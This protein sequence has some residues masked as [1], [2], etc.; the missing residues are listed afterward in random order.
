MAL[1]RSG[2]TAVPSGPSADA[3]IAAM[4]SAL[5]VLDRG[6]RIAAVNAAA[7]IFLNASAGY[8]MHKPFG[9]IL[10]LPESCLAGLREEAVFASF[11]CF[12]DRPR[13]GRTRIDFHSTPLPDHEGWRLVS[14]H[15]AAAAQAIGDRRNGSRT[16]IGVAAMLAHEIKNPLSGIRGAAQ[17]LDAE[18][19]PEARRMTKLIRDEVDRVAGLIDRMEQFTDNRPLV[20]APENIYAILDH[21]RA[22]ATSGFGLNVDMKDAFDPSLPPVLVHRDS[23]VQIVL[24][25]LKNASEA[26]PKGKRG[27]IW[28]TTGYRH[29]VAVPGEGGRRL[30][31]P[32]E[33]CVIDDGPGPPPEIADHLFEPF[34]SS[35]SSGRGLGL[36][37]VDK[38]VRDNGG[39]IQFAREGKPER[40]VFRMLLPRAR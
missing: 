10:R 4:P 2:L 1:A 30:S 39:I 19:S 38:L 34:V 6:G 28:L 37:L 15:G 8:L 29:G 18:A 40:S 25:L 14:L 13:G 31:V 27:T 12:V 16:A 7:E 22:V 24:N 35:K 17:L 3:L 33:L 20:R 23:M 26:V 36:A 5:V 32:I 11:D 9:L 21:A